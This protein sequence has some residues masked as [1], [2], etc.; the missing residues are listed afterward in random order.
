MA[1]PCQKYRQVAV[2]LIQTQTEVL[3]RNIKHCSAPT[4][5][6]EAGADRLHSGVYA[7]I[8]EELQVPLQLNRPCLLLHAKL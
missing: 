2:L 6:L 1:E 8:F 7:C 5:L 3:S 4:W